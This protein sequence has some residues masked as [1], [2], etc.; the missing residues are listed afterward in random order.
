MVIMGQALSQQP[1]PR[2][3]GFVPCRD[4]VEVAAFF[5]KE[6][7]QERFLKSWDFLPRKSPSARCNS[8]TIVTGSLGLKAL[9]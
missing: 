7:K 8:S 3:P 4:L 9:A 2:K 5:T 6:P 1:D